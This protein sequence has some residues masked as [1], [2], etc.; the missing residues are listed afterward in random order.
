[1]KEMTKKKYLIVGGVA[2]GASTAAR[3]RRLDEHA[4]II[5]FERGS[6]ISYAN[7]GLPYYLG[8]VIQDR[9]NLLVQ[10]AEAFKARFNVDVRVASTVTRI[11]R[12]T[13]TLT[14]LDMKS[15][16]VYTE[17]YD[18]LILS[19]GAAPIKPDVPGIQS[20]GIFTLRSVSDTDLIKEYISNNSLTRAVVIGAGYIGVEMAENLS[21]AGLVVTIVEK[22]HQVL[23]VLDF[24]V[25]A[26]V[27]QYL[28]TK[29]IQ[30]V[31][32]NAVT[33]FSRVDG[34]LTLTLADG[35]SITT[36]LVIVSIGVRAESE[37]ARTAGLFIG[38]HGGIIV[39]EYLQT[40][41]KDIYAVGDAIEFISPITGKPLPTYLAGPASKQGRICA[42]N[43]VL[44]NK[45]TFNGSINSAIVKIF[46]MTVGIAGSSS[47]ALHASKVRHCISVTH[48]NSHS[49][50]YPDSKRLSIHITFCCDTGKLLGAQVIGF[51]GVD[52]RLDVLASII[53]REGTIFDLVEFEQAYAPP[54]SAAK[55][56]VNVAGLVADNIFTGLAKVC[57]VE[58]VEKIS[59]KSFVLDVRQPS[60]F[61]SGHIPGAVNIPLPELRSRI[62]EIPANS[63]VMV[64]CQVGLRGYVAQRILLQRGIEKVKN[65][66]GGYLSWSIFDSE[67]TK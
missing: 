35:N 38:S 7:C 4:E 65:L 51:A 36:D 2:G 27:Q 10:T 17:S 59:G 30:L 62:N 14:I 46:D 22:S 13:K 19:P 24:P 41:D 11:D 45:Y 8:G 12:S 56:P 57:Y 15:G 9:A 3:L 44:G 21:H 49:T 1:M 63:A 55:D 26:T 23:P 42:N 31:L 29:D 67:L 20:E 58:D 43:L 25:A 50:Y 54:F 18:K 40:S 47:R 34:A 53:K 52:K 33:S 16:Q 61:Q 37:L 60:E 66:S 5:I 48:G 32:E 28:R 6:Y 39:D 64:Y